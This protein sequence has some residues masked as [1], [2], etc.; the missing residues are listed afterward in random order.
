MVQQP[1]GNKEWQKYLI[2]PNH[3]QPPEPSSP[4]TFPPSQHPSYP[5]LSTSFLPTYLPTY[6]HLLHDPHPH[7]TPILL[8]FSSY[9]TTLPTRKS[10]NSHNLYPTLPY[11]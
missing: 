7:P 11:L 8:T 5:Y 1:W 4:N 2:H 9:P 3:H 6:P 10:W